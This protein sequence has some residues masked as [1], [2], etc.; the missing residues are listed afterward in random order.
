MGDAP[1]H[2]VRMYDAQPRFQSLSFEGE[3]TALALAPPPEYA[4]IEG[5][6]RQRIMSNVPRALGSPRLI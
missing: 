2:S 4:N 3:E 6:S 5:R 1:Q